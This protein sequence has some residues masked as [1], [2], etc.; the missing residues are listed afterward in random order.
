MLYVVFCFQQSCSCVEFLLI[1]RM[2][3]VSVTDGAA[4]MAGSA[5]IGMFV[6]YVC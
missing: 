4:A 1:Y 2:L 5:I 3:L 6:K